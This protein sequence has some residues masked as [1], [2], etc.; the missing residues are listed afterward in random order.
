MEHKTKQYLIVT[1][2]GVTLF[3]VLFHLPNVIGVLEQVF[4]LILPII[5]GGILSIFFA[6]PMNG[7]EK[8]LTKIF[9]KTKKPPS[10]KLLH[11]LSFVLALLC[12]IL[13]LVLVFTLLIPEIIRSS[14]NL[15]IQLEEMI[16]QWL[17]YLEGKGINASWLDEL[18][19]GLSLEKVMGSV[20]SGINTLLTNVVGALSSTLNF[21]LTT[22]FAL[23]I[24]FYIVLNKERLCGHARKLI[25]AYWNPKW[26]DRTLWFCRMFSQSFTKFLTGQCTEAVI[27]GVLMFL[28]FTV[29]K[30]PY[31]SLVGLLTAVC[32]I[33]PYIGAFTSLGISLLFTLLNAPSLALRCIVVC[34][35]VQFIENQFIYPRVVGSSVGLPPVYMLIAALLGGKLFGIAGI[36]FFIPIAAVVFDFVKEDISERVKH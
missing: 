32:A 9:K 20:S 8:G 11:I 4:H 1:V 3:A 36:I 6:V 33:I 26:A 27:L 17:T 19:A 29:F 18:F 31:A 12:V 13:V 23:I 24:S 35:V 21:I 25:L 28:A 5:V 22:G 7:I 14:Q 2:C 30:L 34:F 10:A 15:L 16:P